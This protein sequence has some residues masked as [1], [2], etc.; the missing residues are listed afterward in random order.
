MAINYNNRQFRVVST[1]DS[2]EVPEAFVFT[3]RQ[4]GDILTCSYAGGTIRAG[5]LLGLVDSDG[6]I[7]FRYHQVLASGELQTGECTSRPEVLPN[8]KLRLHESWRWTSGD[9]AL[10]TSVLEEV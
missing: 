4:E 1:S 5:H 10:G 3:Y 6:H 9:G 8:G 7:A 2:G